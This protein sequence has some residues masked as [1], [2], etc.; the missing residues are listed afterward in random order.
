MQQEWHAHAPLALLARVVEG[1]G[2]LPFTVFAPVL[3][4]KMFCYYNESKVVFALSI[5]FGN[6]SRIIHIKII[7]IQLKGKQ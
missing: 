5:Y 4:L 6:T 3:K 7:I 1:D 2:A